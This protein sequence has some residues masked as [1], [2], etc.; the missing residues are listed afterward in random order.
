MGEIFCGTCH[1][2]CHCFPF[3][4]KTEGGSQRWFPYLNLLPPGHA[5]TS[6]LSPSHGKFRL[7]QLHLDVCFPP[8]F[9]NHSK[10]LRPNRTMSQSGLTFCRSPARNTSQQFLLVF[11]LKYVKAAVGS[12]LTT[13]QCLSLYGS[14]TS[15]FLQSRALCL[16]AVIPRSWDHKA[17]S[18]NHRA[19]RDG[20]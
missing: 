8:Q 15:H 6:S 3:W 20:Q 1:W 5:P 18:K 12:C 7:L 17:Y 10:M 11:N 4:P 13:F 16:K 19:F 14:H 9:K 2:H